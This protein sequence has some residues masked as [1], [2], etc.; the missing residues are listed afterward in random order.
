[1][2]DDTAPAARSFAPGSRYA[3]LSTAVWRAPDGSGV[4]YVRRRFCPLPHTLPLLVDAPVAPADRPDRVAA[5]TLGD[6][7]QFWRVADAN[8]AM[9]PFELT[10]RPGRLLR[11]PAPLLPGHG[12]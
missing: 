11:I 6:P 8:A 2:A 10:A 3:P 5:R 4:A 12:G 7:L 9:D 1:M